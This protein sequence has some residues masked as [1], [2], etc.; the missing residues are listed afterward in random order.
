MD[1]GAAVPTLGLA[2]MVA[3]LFALHIFRGPKEQ[4]AMLRKELDEVRRDLETLRTYHYAL[5]ERVARE[6]HDKTEVR[7]IVTQ[8]HRRLDEILKR[9][10]GRESS[11]GRAG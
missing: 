4:D 11:G 5:A 6:Y 9:L 1:W 8:I 2:A 3:G 10:D 7:D